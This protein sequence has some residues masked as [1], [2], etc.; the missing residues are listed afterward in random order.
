[1]IHSS[2]ASAMKHVIG[3]C[4]VL[5][6]LVAPARAQFDTAVVPGTNTYARPY[7]VVR[8]EVE[9]LPDGTGPGDF[10][11]DPASANNAETALS[12]R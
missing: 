4:L 12:L 11:A 7:V 9:T 1:M 8:I 3:A 5:A 10:L 6:V 2:L